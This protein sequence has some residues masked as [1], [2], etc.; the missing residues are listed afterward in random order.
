MP[1]FEL[2]NKPN[3]TKSFDDFFKVPSFKQPIGAAGP[4][5]IFFFL[6]IPLKAISFYG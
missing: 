4:S 2:E 6:T 1:R 3:C 5:Y